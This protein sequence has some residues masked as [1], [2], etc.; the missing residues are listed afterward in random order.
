MYLYGSTSAD[1][2]LRCEKMIKL[3][4]F[5]LTCHTLKLKKKEFF[6]MVTK[7]RLFL[8]WSFKPDGM[9]SNIL[10]LKHANPKH[11]SKY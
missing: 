3:A 11:V 6:S 10:A 8:G 2:I 1:N 4:M 9:M 5:V 7:A